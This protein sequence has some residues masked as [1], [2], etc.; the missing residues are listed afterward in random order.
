MIQKRRL[1]RKYRLLLGFV[2]GLGLVLIRA[3]LGFL[4]LADTPWP[5]RGH[6]LKHTGISPYSGSQTSTKKWEFS[7]GDKI[8]SSPAI[9]ADG[10]IYV[11]SWDGK[12]YAIG[13]S[14]L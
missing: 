4:Q 8:A 11:G 9:G 6:D 12:L 7:A 2:L 5:M 13:S 1:I 3:N 14:I 10:T